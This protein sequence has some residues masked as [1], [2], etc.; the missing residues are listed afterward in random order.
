MHLRRIRRDAD[1]YR[2]AFPAEAAD[3]GMIADFI[4]RSARK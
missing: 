4:R 2:L 1:G 3:V